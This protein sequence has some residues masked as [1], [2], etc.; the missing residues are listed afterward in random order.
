MLRLQASAAATG[1]N[2]ILLLK[3]NTQ[4]FLGGSNSK[5]KVNFKKS[6]PSQNSNHKVIA[7][8]EFLKGKAFLWLEILYLKTL[9]L[10]K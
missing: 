5:I 7:Y 8:I 9:R 1:F 3:R 2:Y 4:M 10:T 6:I